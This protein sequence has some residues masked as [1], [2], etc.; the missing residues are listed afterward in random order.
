MRPRSAVLVALLVAAVGCSSPT[1]RQDVTAQPSSTKDFTCRDAG[2]AILTRVGRAV[3]AGERLESGSVIDYQTGV[4]RVAAPFRDDVLAFATDIDPDS[5]GPGVL[6]A[7]ND[8]TEQAFR[9]P[10]HQD[11]AVLLLASI[12]DSAIGQ[13]VDCAFA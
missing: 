6:V 7:A 8:Y 12:D 1:P 5:G 3:K 10:R 2:A 13:V 4:W 9:E 11:P